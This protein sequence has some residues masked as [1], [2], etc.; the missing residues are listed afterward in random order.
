MCSVY[1]TSIRTVNLHIFLQLERDIARLSKLGEICVSGDL[2]ART[3]SLKDYIC[4][5]QINKYIKNCN[6][7]SRDLQKHKMIRCNQYVKINI[8]G[9]ELVDLCKSAI[10]RICNGRTV[11]DLCGDFTLIKDRGKS[12]VHLT[13]GEP[14]YLSDHNLV[15]T[16]FK[17]QIKR[18]TPKGKIS[19]MRK[20]YDKF[21]WQSESSVLYK[22]ALTEVD[23]QAMIMNDLEVQGVLTQ[24]LMISPLF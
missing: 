18:D 6:D 20:E 14:T 10:L 11:S 1:I 22:E 9:R 12:L 23:S 19:N 3:G 24:L 2:N 17:C 8:R 7:Y 15:E 16:V 4:N 5:D 13:I 21:I